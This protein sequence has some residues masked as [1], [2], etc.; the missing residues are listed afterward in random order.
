MSCALS[1]IIECLGSEDKS[2]STSPP[3][4]MDMRRIASYATTDVSYVS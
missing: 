3:D 1:C 2:T 4:D